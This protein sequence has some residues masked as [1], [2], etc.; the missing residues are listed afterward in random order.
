MS[1]RAPTGGP[2]A[3]PRGAVDSGLSAAERDADRLRVLHPA[4]PI[5]E[6]EERRAAGTSPGGPR[7]R[8]LR[9]SARLRDLVRETRVSP[10]QLIMPHFVLPAARA[11]EPVPSMPGISRLGVEDLVERVLA[12]AELGIRAVLLF[13]TPPEG[14]KDEHGTAA[15]AHDSAVARATE[16]LKGALGDD[17]LVITDV[18]LCA[19]TSH[20][21]CGVLKGSTGGEGSRQGRQ[22]RLQAGALQGAGE[23]LNDET[24][25]LLAE[26]ALAHARAGA[27][28]VA[29]SD[30]M[31]GRVA[32]IRVR[33]DEEG[34]A[35]VGILS[36]A[37]K[38]AS[39][40]YGP[41]RD[42]A[43]SSPA[44]GDRK[45]HQMDPA[46]VREAIREARLDEAEGADMLMV[47][48]ALAYL[49]VVRAVREA[50]TL[51][52]ACYNVSGEYS[53]VKAAAERGWMDEGAVVAE[54]L[55]AMARA[56]ADV[57]ITY[58]ARE[59]LENGWL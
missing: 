53:A 25:P 26:V 36:Y 41:F 37:V 20:G 52:L 45:S 42:A 24:L 44:T 17:L 50:T 31:D 35:G 22:G 49:D 33:L 7:P 46:N 29:P 13:G 11:E 47:K 16:A 40:Y 51:P 58:H 56:G 23:I 3:A 34:F 32:A 19:Y 4:P 2:G 14:M 39:A 27:D 8:R 57:I 59:A 55:R 9:R 38:Y 43:D 28:L 6:Q 5:R 54:N 12:D 15:A 30:M 18:C 1:R 48:P 10:E 21:H